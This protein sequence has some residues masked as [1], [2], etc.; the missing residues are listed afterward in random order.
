[1]RIIK[2]QSGRILLE[3]PGEAL[4][5]LPAL[6]YRRILEASK[7]EGVEI[8]DEVSKAPSTKLL[9][10]N[11]VARD[12]QVESVDAWERTGRR[13]IIVLPTGAGKTI[14]A[15]KAMENTQVATL[16]VVPTIVLLEQW[17]KTLEEAFRVP[18]GGLGGGYDE[19][20]PITVATY[21]SAALRATNIGNLFHLIIFDEVHHLPTP[22]NS[23]I[24]L[25][26]IAS[27]RLGLTATL[28]EEPKVLESLE[29]LVGPVIY[30]KK[31]DD[32]TGIH[33]SE[34]T[35]R[36]IPIPLTPKEKLDYDR[37]Y[38]AYRSF[39]QR[40]GIKIRSAADYM[41]FLRRSGVDPEARRALL[42]RNAAMDIA[43]NSSGK[44]N[45]LKTVL[46]A[47]PGVKTIIFTRHNKLVYKISK[48][49]LIPAITHQTIS[50]E[51]KSILDNFKS[52]SY[53][54]IITSQV[55]DEG[56][57]VPDAALAVILS[58]TGSSRQF[59]QRLGRIL[60]KREGKQAVLIELVSMETA[61][62]RISQRRKQE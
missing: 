35:I 20:K 53:R 23:G 52:G 26:Y 14:V 13:G 22:R 48:L 29:Q 43:L 17:R 36:T 37:M 61:E 10:S 33:L 40:S 51:R 7:S 30:R 54:R 16:V 42:A 5:R 25:N 24:G 39:L 56:I 62:T 12:Y 57:D 45:Y 2:F 8:I 18:I 38:Q 34:Y 4:I 46:K 31:V 28:G 9:K 32:L 11:F 59:I 1:M 49:L 6:E 19:I 47:N 27:M 50:E 55:L 3:D 44:I 58:G 41:S 60:R 15:I 21:D